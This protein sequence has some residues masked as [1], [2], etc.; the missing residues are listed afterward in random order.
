M[1]YVH[2]YKLFYFMMH[3]KSRLCP[4][5]VTAMFFCWACLQW[6]L[7]ALVPTGSR[8]IYFLK[9]MLSKI[10]NYFP[11]FWHI[12]QLVL[13]LRL[14]FLIYLW[15]LEFSLNEVKMCQ[16]RDT[17]NWMICVCVCFVTGGTIRLL[18]ISTAKESG[19]RR[20]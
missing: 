1:F 2:V 4:H 13:T 5:L 20:R 15:G 19:R 6:M 8:I 11:N 7:V 12:P 9:V 18:L 16:I 17:Y 10:T 3:Y 14:L